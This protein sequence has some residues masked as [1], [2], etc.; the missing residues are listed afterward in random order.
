MNLKEVESTMVQLNRRFQECIS[1]AKVRLHV[2]PHF[3]LAL[4][5]T[6]SRLII[7]S[8]VHALMYVQLPL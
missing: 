2:R 6:I 4:L 1:R 5:A 7:T 8:S 3:Y